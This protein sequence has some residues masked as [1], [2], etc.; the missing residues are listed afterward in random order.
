LKTKAP[1]LTA[2]QPL[3]APR[4]LT[5]DLVQRL[6]ADIIDGKLAPGARLP[7]EQQLI[8]ATGVSRTVVREAV[9]A[10][11]AEGLVFTR[12]G[13]G[14]FVADTVRRP[15]RIEPDDVR[16]IREVIEVM[17]LRTGIEIEAAGL[18]AERASREDI[19]AIAGAFDNIEQAIKRGESGIE[20]DFAF[21]RAIAHATG[22]PQ[23]LRFLNY[24]GHFIIPRQSVNLT[25]DASER[26]VYL[27]TFQKEH[28][29]ILSAIKARSVAQ[30]RAAMQRHLL[31]SRK[32]YKK[33]AARL[34]AR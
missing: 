18:A 30:A 9:A 14:A 31:N 34:E 17:E 16:S 22:N 21:H 8:E 12:Q 19:A 4:S 6:S 5:H 10:L 25:T 32:R 3:T 23:F 29:V 15:F 28:T 1:T 13:V 11:R 33:L 20:Q 2:F 27:R 24:L 26:S 7:T